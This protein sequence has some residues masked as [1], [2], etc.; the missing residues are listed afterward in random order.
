MSASKRRMHSEDSGLLKKIFKPLANV[1]SII[2]RWL[3]D[4][5]YGISVV[6]NKAFRKIF[7]REN[8]MATMSTKRRKELIFFICLVV[9]PM[10]QFLVFYVGVNIN[11][12]LLAFQK[13]DIDTSTFAFLSGK[14]L[15]A[16]FSQFIDDMLHNA[17]MIT[18][19]KNSIKL[20]VVGL[21]VGLPLNLVFS[22][23]LYKKI[24]GSGFYR[25]VL[26]LPQIISS[27]VVSLMFRYFIE[28]ALYSLTGVNLLVEKA[29]AFN[30]MIFY[31]VWA[32]FGSAIIIYTSA[33]SKIDDSLVEFG[34]LE[35][36][37]TL[38][39][40]W[41][42]TLPLIFPTITIFLVSGIAGLFTSQA[43]LFNFYGTGAHEHMHTL[44]YI[45]FVKIMKSEEVSLPQYPYASA[46]GLLFTL[47]ATPVTLFVK[48]GL[49]KID[50]NFD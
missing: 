11:S 35:G 34:Q 32:G 6:I 2:V 41:Y 30:T 37:S 44:G 39:E 40:F 22:F 50:P 4:F 7:N 49:E 8:K 45:F 33:M 17:G 46:A 16:N 1:F 27:L 9:Y 13:F 23:F 18:A 20:Y 43:S 15:F 21:V 29:T 24:P 10:L 38:Q 48:W 28:V 47:V 14:E 36:I 26:F 12:V 42:V 3:K 25:V 19:T 31:N 5:F